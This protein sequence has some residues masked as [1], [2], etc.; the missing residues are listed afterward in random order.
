MWDN[1]PGIPEDR[2]QDIFNEF[3]RIDRKGAELGLGLGLAI[4]R[5]ISRILNQP[6]NLRSWPGQGTVFSITANI[7]LRL[8][9]ATLA[10]RLTIRQKTAS[11]WL[12]FVCYALI[13]KKTSLPE[14]K[15]C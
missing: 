9:T 11:R 15:A 13:M 4:A 14:W 6:L 12:G 1:G 3:T 10:L 8:S 5:G 2:Q 7:E